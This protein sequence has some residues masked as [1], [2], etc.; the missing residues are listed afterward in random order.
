MVIG[1][2]NDDV[3]VSITFGQPTPYAVFVNSSSYSFPTAALSAAGLSSTI[4]YPDM[5]DHH[6]INAALAPAYVAG[7]AQVVRPDL[8]GIADYDRTTSDHY[9]IA[10]RYELGGGSSSAPYVFINEVRYSEP[11]SP[12]APAGY[13]HEFVELINAGD[14]TAQ[15]SGWAIWDASG[16]RHVFPAGT[17]LA[18]GKAIVVFG[19]ASAVSASGLAN[20][21]A[22]SSGGLNFH[23]I[24]SVSLRDAAGSTVDGHAWSADRAPGVSD[25][26]SA[27]GVP[28]LEF[29]PHQGLS[30]LMSSAGVQANGSAF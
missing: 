18:P 4:G 30:P 12:P 9:P 28:G 24:D 14:A 5:I 25:N 16:A 29:H 8:S 10:T 19:G 2:F 27:D 22:A 13:D 11:S 7:S 6:L 21:V 20:A 26:R 23:P 15:L 17:T 1:D 3:D